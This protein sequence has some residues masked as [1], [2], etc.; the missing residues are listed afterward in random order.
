MGLFSDE[1][2]EARREKAEARK[3]KVAKL[4]AK[5]DG[6]SGRCTSCGSDLNKI[7]HRMPSTDPAKVY[8][9]KC[10]SCHSMQPWAPAQ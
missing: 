6:L 3:A 10:P 8:Y 5:S 2:K 1:K 9:P 7:P 4:Q